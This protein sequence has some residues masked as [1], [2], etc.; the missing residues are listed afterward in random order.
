MFTFSN[1]NCYSIRGPCQIGH[2]LICY[3]KFLNIRTPL[4]NE[5][6]IPLCLPS[7]VQW[8]AS[9]AASPVPDSEIHH[10]SSISLAPLQVAHRACTFDKG[11]TY[12]LLHVL[13]LIASWY[14][15]SYSSALDMG[16]ETIIPTKLSQRSFSW[17]SLTFGSTY[18]T[19]L[20]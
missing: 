4:E 2:H 7:L 11:Y 17:Y 20:L 5:N 3:L 14:A 6:D 18:I 8:P 1:S 16:R 15:F 10:C 9:C 19:L 13:S 12:G